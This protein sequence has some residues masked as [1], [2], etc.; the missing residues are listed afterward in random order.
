[1]KLSSSLLGRVGLAGVAA[2]ALSPLAMRASAE[3]APSRL[4]TPMVD[5]AAGGG[6]RTAV[7][8]GGCFWG[9]EGVFEHVKGV[10]SAESGYVGGQ[11][12]TANYET[13]ST[14][15]T[16]HAESVRV[17]YD[18]RQV[19]YG[20]L[21]Q[22][23]FSVA[24]DPTEVNRQGPDSGTQYRSAI[25][26]TTTGQ[27]AAAQAYIAQLERAKIYPRPIATKVENNLPFFV[28]EAHHQ[29]FLAL[30]PDHPYIANVDMPKVAAL[31][32]LF[33]TVYRNGSAVKTAGL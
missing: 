8:A 25:F 31:K 5:E 15:I 11:K 17:V 6:L 7:F 24:L 10:R 12:A 21:L 22:V 3:I 1:M 16:G 20:K 26:A 32:S 28:A 30:H 14:G 9:V 4:P 27:K 23:F 19:S 18:P 29:N 2:L 13:V 33:P